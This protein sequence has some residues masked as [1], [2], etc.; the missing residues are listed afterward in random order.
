MF[1]L[2]ALALPI[3][4]GLCYSFENSVRSRPVVH[5]G[6]NDIVVHIVT[7]KP[8]RGRMY[9]Q[10][11]AENP[12]CIHTAK[13][14]KNQFHFG[15]PIG[16]CNMR[17]QRTMH[18]RGVSFSFTLIVSFHP[19]FVTGMD[20][21]FHVSCFFLES[22]K[23]VGTKYGVSNSRMSLE[24]V[25]QEFQ[26]PDCFYQ[27]HDGENGPAIQ[28]AQVG[29]R[30]THRWTCEDG[31][32]STFIYG[33]L[34]HSCF[35]DDGQSNKFE[36]VDDRGCSTDNYLLPQI[37]YNPKSL[38]AS[39]ET[40]V[41]KYAD[42]V[43]LFFTCTVQL[44][45][46]HDGGCEGITPPSCEN[47]EPEHLKHDDGPTS[48]GPPKGPPFKIAERPMVP[49]GPP[50]PHPAPREDFRPHEVNGHR[51]GRP[52]H[53]S[54]SHDHSMDSHEG[55]HSSEDDQHTKPF[56]G[57]IE[58]SVDFDSQ[59]YRDSPL[60]ET[61]ADDMPGI[62][63]NITANRIATNKGALSDKTKKKRRDLNMETDLSI[64]VIVLPFEK[65]KPGQPF[66][67]SHICISRAASV[68]LLVVALVTT[69]LCVI[70]TMVI[71]RRKR[72]YAKSMDAFH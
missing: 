61:D 55:S 51:G 44:C 25:E 37:Q 26:L 46:K 3:S 59:P 22:V 13:D 2:V 30:V 63:G 43:Q 56:F 47:T 68:L 6:G 11:E 34:I 53:R 71:T 72:F 42:K 4:L 57:P 58:S 36:L 66:L 15:L 14:H 24:V 38:S 70:I 10:G 29:Q 67:Q 45:Y 19:F 35:A 62:F 49:H 1:V 12:Q 28:F 7:D 17:R 52:E 54:G 65:T 32:G 40:L 18:P 27:L 16:A 9:V 39:A 41:F 20:R 60:N 21:A 5:C 23:N 69:I 48:K 8:F 33:L 31:S 64:D 50:P